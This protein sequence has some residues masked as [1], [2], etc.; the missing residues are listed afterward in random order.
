MPMT[1]SPAVLIVFPWCVDRLGHGNVQR[2]LAMAS[3]LSRQGFAVDLVYQGNPRVPSREHELTGFRRVVRVSAWES[4]DA[5]RL[6]DEWEAF[7]AGYDPPPPNLSAGTA[8]TSVVRGLL[9]TGEYAAVIATYAW[10]APIFARVPPHVLRVVDVQDVISLHAERAR[11]ATGTMPAFSM[12]V[13]TERFLWRQWDVLLAITPDEARAIAPFLRPSQRLLTVPHAVAIAGDDAKVDAADTVV[14]TGSDNPSNQ[15]AVSWLLTEVW[16]RVLAARPHARL[17]LV[18][19]ICDAIRRTPLTATPNVDLVGFVDR[20]MDEVAKASVCVAPYLYGSGLKIKVIEAAGARRAIVTTPAGADGTGFVDGAHALIAPDSATFASA[21]VR[22]LGD[23]ALRGRLAV[24]AR[25]HARQHFSDEACYGALVALLRAPE[26][27]VAATGIIPR[28]IEQ[29]LRTALA[30]LDSPAAV[31]WGNGSHT[32]ALLPVLSALGARVRCIVDKSAAIES[33]SPEGIAIV[34]ANAFAPR[35]DDLIVLSSQAYEWDMWEDLAPIRATGAHALALYCRELITDGLA[36]I[37]RGGTQ[38]PPSSR[39]ATSRVAPTRLV[40]VEPSAGRGNGPFLRLARSLH[41][42][43]RDTLRVVVAGARRISPDGLESTDRELLEPAFD[44]TYLDALRE[45]REDMWRG[46]ARFSRLQA[47]DLA[48]LSD[49]LTLTSADVVLFHSTTLLDAFGAA[50]WMTTRPDRDVPEIRFLFHVA[51]EQEARWLNASADAVRHAYA[52]ALALIDDRVDGRVRLLAQNDALAERLERAFDRPVDV[53]GFPV[54]SRSRAVNRLAPARPARLLYAGEA[55]AEKG[56]GLLPAIADAL[57]RELRDGRLRIVCQSMRGGI[58]DAR[59]EAAARALAARPGVERIER[60]LPS[61]EY[62]ALVAGCDL[63]LLPYDAAEYRARLSA[64]FVDATC[65]GVPVI[66]PDGTWM[67]GQIAEGAGA[68]W[69]FASLD[70]ARIADVIRG[71]LTSLPSMR[72]AARR[73][74]DRAWQQHDPRV[75][76]ETILRSTDASPARHATVA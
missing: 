47:L 16:P 50:Q 44:F 20:P 30:A 37:A 65:A 68:G 36:R 69:T 62:D 4:A 45:I 51:L 23:E 64:V 33:V 61:D 43:S 14:Y 75:V 70:A 29:R 6:H 41:E 72:D 53:M 38:R 24:A 12:A 39:P 34:P 35:P 56:F 10:T 28:A 42:V 13:E 55:R 11:A 46:V 59:V 17:R 26:S 2:V 15:A 48:R 67:S 63:V 60:F 73:A 58:A 18:G 3:H 31:V 66:V 40:I 71:A 32:R 25:E 21:I 54:P 27:P 19:L 49:R 57:D 74:S 22:L 5:L 52:V 9:D 8:L 1:S 76:L 7:Y